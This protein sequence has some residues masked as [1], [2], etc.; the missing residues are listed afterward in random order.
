LVPHELIDRIIIGPCRYPWVTYE[1]FC[2]LLTDLQIANPHER[3]IV[4][5]TPLRVEV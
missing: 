2:R 5:D 3:V 1:A 4:S